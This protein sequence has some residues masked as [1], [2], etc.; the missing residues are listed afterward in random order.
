MR[1]LF[2]HICTVIFCLQF[3][4]AFA[5]DAGH[6]T[7]DRAFVDRVVVDVGARTVAL[8]GWA[9]SRAETVGSPRVDVFVGEREIY[10][11]YPQ[12]Q[13]RPDV[14]KDTGRPEWLNSGWTMTVPL[15]AVATPGRQSLLVKVQFDEEAPITSHASAP[16]NAWINIPAGQVR[17]RVW[18][19]LGIA[20]G[21]VFV[22]FFFSSSLHRALVK[23]SQVAIPEP[24]VPALALVFCFAVFVALGV[25]GS[26]LAETQEPLPIAGIKTTVFANEAQ[27]IRSDEWLVLTNMAI[28]QARHTPAFPVVN[29]NLG[30][31]GQNML[32]VGM[33]SVPVWRLSAL[34]RPATWGYFFLPL[35]QAL[36]WH[37]WFP[38]F[39]CVLGIWACFCILFPGHWRICLVLAVCF[40]SSPYVVAW[41]YWPAYVSMFAAIAFA[42]FNQLLKD[43][44]RWSMPLQALLLGIGASG[45][46]LTLYPAWQIPLAYLFAL[47]LGAVLFRDCHLLK[48]SASNALWATFGLV[49]AAIVVASWWLDARD[50]VAAMIATIYPGQRSMESG[51]GID[52]WYFAR[53]LTNFITLYSDLGGV[54]NA[55]EVSSFLYLTLPAL[56]GAS[57]NIAHVKRARPILVVVVAF[58][59]FAFWYQFIG[60]PVWLAKL[61]LLGRSFATRVDLAVGV[62]SLVLLGCAL[63]GTGE[64]QS[65]NESPMRSRKLVAGITAALW[66][67]FIWWSVQFVPDPIAKLLHRPQLVG[68]L[69]AVACCSWLLVAKWPKAFLAFYT[70]MLLY[71]TGA[72]NPW[73]LITESAAEQISAKEAA[74]GTGGGRT[75]VLGSNVPPM[76]LMASGCPVL[77]GVSYYPQMRLWRSLDPDGAQS[78]AY[79]RYQR[80]FF[81]VADLHGSA[82]PVIAATQTDTVTVLLDSKSFDFS[83][84]P[85]STVLAKTEERED[86]DA[87][88]SLKRIASPLRGFDMFTVVR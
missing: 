80:L 61:S 43:N 69:L 62:A 12:R 81:K 60:F 87:N 56:V 55:S 66:T 5:A 50:A 58:L 47:L 73:T 28:G 48:L 54:S 57:L 4:P 3:A 64:C 84:L 70:L 74:C 88:G 15:T 32:V 10:S 63:T 40:V 39:G 49:F 44:R 35:P 53:G 71:T 25:S 41:S 9:V 18:I 86:L 31:D 68:V 36:A 1:K 23:F 17:I 46:V 16:E 83:R 42:S 52:H 75:L 38:V 34:G 14:V 77:D 22:G 7:P 72:F 65:G 59:A 20:I 37:W 29:N 19:G 76:V 6:E 79:N 21:V 27:G 85:I 51:G 2:L 78:D 26:S 33:T 82:R 24:A 8:T 30:P 45:F 11:G 67:A 13:A